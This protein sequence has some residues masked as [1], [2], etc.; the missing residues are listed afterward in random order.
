MR[1]R[2]KGR[3][4]R[5]LILGMVMA[6]A[7]AACGDDDDDAASGD[8][9]T[10]TAPV[11]GDAT[12]TAP[13]PTTTGAE[14]PTTVAEETPTTEAVDPSLPTVGDD[15]RLVPGTCPEGTPNA[16]EDLGITED[17]LNMALVSIDFKPLADIGFAA[18]G[19]DVT[20]FA[21]PFI[22]AINEAGGICG[23]QIDYQPLL[24]DILARE[25]GAACLKVTEDRRNVMVFGQGGWNE[26]TCVAE[27][28]TVIIGQQDFSEGAV[29]AAGGDLGIMFAIP[30]SIEQAFATSAEYY[31]ADLEGKKVGVWYGAVFPEHGDAVEQA[32]FPILDEAGIDYISYR[33]DFTGPTD[34]QGGA[35]LSTA[36]TD[37]VSQSVDVVLGF[38]QTTNHVGLQNEMNNQ[39]LVPT[40]LWSNIGSN[41]ANELFHKAFNTAEVADGERVMTYT[42]PP[43]LTGEA[44]WAQSC[45]EQLVELG[46][47]EFEPGTFDY[48]AASNICTQVDMLVAVLTQVGPEITQEKIVAALEGLPAFPMQ[49]TLV[50]KQWGPGVRFASR[51]MQE[52][53][54]DGATNSYSLQGELIEIA[55]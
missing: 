32:V 17:T 48:A 14:A 44:A 10:T 53:V 4:A 11:E 6:L 1:F 37:F 42:L 38:T 3:W 8:A 43:S 13:A 50:P 5:L 31:L 7:A 49:N 34:P 25:G 18:S 33:T 55:P 20:Q 15:G 45:N 52:L 22:D 39:G 24:Y 54:Y 23:R 19:T 2:S 12:T 9:E 29:E 30:P 27:A 26:A 28:G 46:G 40:W 21:I 41:S 16:D 36:A 51:G 47:E 35:I